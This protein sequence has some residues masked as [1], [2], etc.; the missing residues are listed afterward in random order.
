MP[1][2]EDAHKEELEYIFETIETMYDILIEF[3]STNNY[4]D[5]SAF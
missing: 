5:K 1:K 4:P 3:H 2:Y